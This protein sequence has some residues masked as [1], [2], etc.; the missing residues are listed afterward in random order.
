MTGVDVDWELP[1]E[2]GCCGE[3]D[4]GVFP[5]EWVYSGV[6]TLEGVWIHMCAHALVYANL[7]YGI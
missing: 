2:C 1:R 7:K 4:G 5:L 6:M 3:S